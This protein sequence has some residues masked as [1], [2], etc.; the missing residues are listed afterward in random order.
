M[1]PFE[2]PPRIRIKLPAMLLTVALGVVGAR[3][4]F[5]Q[6]TQHHD[7]GTRAAKQYLRRVP[8]SPRR[9]TIYDRNGRALAISL[10]GRSVFAHPRFVRD[11]EAT[12]TRLARALRVPARQIRAK[13]RSD[14]PFVWLRRQLDPARA[15]AVA[16]LNLSGVGLVPEGKRYYPKKGLAGHVIG[17]VGVDNQGL[18]GVEFAYDRLLTDGSRSVVSRVDALGRMVFRDGGEGDSGCD[19]YLTIDE[20]I[21]HV[22]ERELD[23][24]VRRSGAKAGTV[25]VM[26]PATGE[27]LALANSPSYN[28]NEYRS[29]HPSFRRNRA[30]TDPYEPGSAFKLILAAAALEERLVRPQDLFYG[31]DG[32]IEVAGV[33]IRDHEKHGWMTFRDVLV[34]SSNVGAIKV[35]MKVGKQRFYSYITGFGFGLPTGADLPGESSGVLR[36]PRDW[37][38]ISIGALSIGYEI[39]ATPLQLITA[40]SAVAN[41][42]QLMRPHV[43]K[44]VQSPDGTVDEI[45]PFPIRR[46][47]SRETTRTLTSILTEVVERG[48]GQAAAFTGYQVAGKTGTAQKLDQKTG[49]YSRTDVVASFIGYVPAKAP[50]LA[51]L[52]LI[53]E[54]G[55]LAWG[56]SVA[57]PAFR[58]IARETLSYLAI[59]PRHPQD[60]RV[61]RR[62]YEAAATIN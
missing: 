29:Y 50:R 22:A 8:V 19:L 25:I 13:L 34:F 26:D 28:P 41:G 20:V 60:E 37:S 38:R 44:A 54:P 48:T 10:N 62:P 1:A 2:R 24:A 32:A 3:L 40:M 4:Y 55:R 7:L 30:V 35:G 14:R 11:P 33:K 23:A 31:E 36:P 12:A 56:G 17:F 58:A 9:G 61:V 15:E 49:R 43:L 52:V 6:I 59:P 51:I 21:Q 57:A 18:E 42:G 27:I 16:D 46:V 5:I 45:R 39:S 53:D 47:A